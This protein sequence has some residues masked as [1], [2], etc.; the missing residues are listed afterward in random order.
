MGLTTT[1]PGAAAADGLGEEASPLPSRPGA[2]ASG[3]RLGL[4]DDP[5]HLRRG[6]LLPVRAVA[7]LVLVAPL[8]FALGL[9]FTGW[10]PTQG[11]VWNASWIGL[12]NYDELFRDDDRFIEAV[13]R[14]LSMSVTCLSLE[15][16][17]GLGLALLFL[18][19]FPGKRL[20]FSVLL[21]PMMILPVVVGYTFWML[22][23]S[24]GP[25]NQVI[26]LL[27]G[28]RLGWLRDPSLA[29]VAVVVTEVWHWTPLFFLVLLSGLNAVPENPVRAAVVLGASPWQVFRDVLLPA[30]RPVIV[31]AFVLRGMEILKLFDE[32]YLL[33]RGGPGTSTE[34]IGLY[35]YKLAFNDFRLSYAAAAAFVVL[36]VT[37]VLIY[38]LLRTVRDQ[39]VS[40]R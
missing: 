19:R 28:A 4:G 26:V 37:L 23:Q 2:A 13:V 34:T 12:D 15:F 1:A 27:S 5:R 8:L 33:T 39:L 7:L 30:I 25:I 35:I 10:S 6:L 18:R 17:L 24:D 9:S 11:S 31:V 3:L 21:A 14:T 40:A 38:A 22:F 20:A 36:V 16:L 32:V 29:F